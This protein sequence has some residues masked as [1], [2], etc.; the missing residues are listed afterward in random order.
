MAPQVCRGRFSRL[1]VRPSLSIGAVER[2]LSLGPKNVSMTAVFLMNGYEGATTIVPN[3]G[4]EG[5][6][7]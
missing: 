1:A 4:M 2:T 6:W 3:G 5:S 7:R